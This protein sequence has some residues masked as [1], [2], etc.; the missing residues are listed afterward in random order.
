MDPFKSN[1]RT[2]GKFQHSQQANPFARAL[3]EAE[4][5]SASRA[6][7][8]SSSQPDSLENFNSNNSGFGN[9]L[10]QPGQ[11][12]SADQLN[13]S[14]S[15]FNAADPVSYTHLTLPTKRIV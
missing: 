14:N 13:Q 12:P 9:N 2:I 8:S 10:T 7:F 5:R 11:F 1:Q 3:A 4:K 15:L 6:G